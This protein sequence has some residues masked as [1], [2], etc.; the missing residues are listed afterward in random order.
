MAGA[1]TY[2]SRSSDF[3]TILLD[4]SIKACFSAAMIALNVV[5]YCIVIIH[6]I[7]DALWS[8]APV[9]ISRSSD[10]GIIS[11]SSDSGIILRQS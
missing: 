2:I 11:R 5:K 1:L 7:K 4:P 6:N 9:L 3:V 8:G 10:S